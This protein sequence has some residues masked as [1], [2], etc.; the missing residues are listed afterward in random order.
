LQATA[1]R[2]RRFPTGRY[3][4]I[5]A[6]LTRQ[7]GE[8]AALHA[9][10]RRGTLEHRLRS[11]TDDIVAVEVMVEAPNRG[12]YRRELEQ[13]FQQEIVVHAPTYERL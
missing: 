13:L 11:E 5:G 9:G 6:K 7:F 12:C 2:R 10:T 1:K 8:L 4:Q 3:N